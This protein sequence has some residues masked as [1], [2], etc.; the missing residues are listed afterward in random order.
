MAD[1]P[2]T[3]M[4]KTKAASSA[5]AS[6]PV[7]QASTQKAMQPAAAPKAKP[8]P[9]PKTS[10]KAKAAIAKEDAASEKERMGSVRKSVVFLAAVAVVYVAYLVISGQFG[11][12]MAA[13]G[14]LDKA[15]V[16]GACLAYVVYY[17][18]GVSAY[19]LAVIKDPT[20]PLGIR[21]LMSV[22]ASGIFFSNLTPNGAGGAP[23]QIY[24]LMRAGLSVGSAGAVQ[25]TRFIIYEAGEGIFAAL[26]LIFRGQWFMDT[27]ADAAWLVALLLFGFKVIEVGALLFV[28]FFPKIV[29]KVGLWIIKF[30]TSHGWMKDPDKWKEMATVQVEEFSK[31]FR[32]AAKNLPE[33]GLTLVVTLLQLACLYALP[34]FVLHAFG[35]EPDLLTCLT[36]GSMLELLTSAIPLPGGTGGAEGGFAVLFGGMFGDANV[37]A[38]YVVWRAVEYFL[39]VLAA[40]P[41]LSLRSNSSESM[42]KRWARFKRRM[43]AGTGKIVRGGRSQGGI[44]V[45]P[46]NLKGKK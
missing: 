32:G 9:K 14:S 38:G 43:H 4:K 21:D 13:L 1:K 20:C 41:L 26:M 29:T 16:V 45:N 5:A 6:A 30:A 31:G 15:W 28:C 42:A 27:Y 39:P 17:F 44:S 24:R 23:A 40:L 3:D 46:K 36:A 12:F 33:L 7:P 18:F 34:W 10:V 37:A 19:V 11:E 22:E 25:Y 35:Q 8:K 2:K